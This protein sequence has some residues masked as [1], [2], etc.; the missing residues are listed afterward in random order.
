MCRDSR[1][2]RILLT[3]LTP[4]SASPASHWT[5]ADPRQ[6]RGG[7]RERQRRNSARTSQARCDAG[8]AASRQRRIREPRFRSGL[9]RQPDRP[10]QRPPR[11]LPPGRTTDHDEATVFVTSSSGLVPREV[12]YTVPSRL[13]GFRKR[14]R[15][16]TSGWNASSAKIWRYLV[17]RPRSNRGTPR[18]RRRLSPCYPWSAPKADGVAQPGLS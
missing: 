8:S 3:W 11:P 1:R 14:A 17:P 13:I 18:S 2:Y 16:P 15:I 4:A 10:A 9:D 7:A 12:F 5:T 6:H